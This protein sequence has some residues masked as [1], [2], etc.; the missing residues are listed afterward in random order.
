M[1][2]VERKN[3]QCPQ[4]T[5]HL[6]N[7]YTY[8]GQNIT[9][10][11]NNAQSESLP[12]LL[13]LLSNSEQCEGGAMPKN[14]ST[15]KLKRSVTLQPLSENLVWVKLP[16]SVVSAVG[17]IVV[18][19]PTQ[20]RCRPAQ[21]LVVRVVTSLWGDGRVPV[22]IVNPTEKPLTLKRN[23]KVADVSPCFTVQD[24]PEPDLIQSS[25][26][27]TQ[28]LSPAPRSKKEVSHVLSDMGLQ[29]LDFSSCEVSLEWKD[30][31]LWTV[32]RLRTLS[33]GYA[34]WMTNPDFDTGGFSHVI[35]TSF[36]LL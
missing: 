1:N 20:S 16:A 31:L 4:L 23:A 12:H 22:K 8:S 5:A 34:W 25:T 2:S 3:V 11:V 24:L 9:P 32:V 27:H 35:M 30:K 19:E 33:T 6:T 10:L 21:I 26:Q 17:S 13:S 36:G 18:I 15:A 14:I 29:D 28:S 7:T